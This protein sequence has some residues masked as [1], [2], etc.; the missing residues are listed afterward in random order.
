MQ[1]KPT[2]PSRT[3]AKFREPGPL[4]RFLQIED[5]CWL[6]HT[7]TF[8]R[9]SGAH[10]IGLAW[11][12]DYRWIF[13]LQTT[14]GDGYTTT[15]FDSHIG[16]RLGWTLQLPSTAN[17]GWRLGW[18]LVYNFL[19]QQTAV[20]VW[21]VRHSTTFSNSKQW[22]AF[23]L[24]GITTSFDSEQWSAFG[25]YL[26]HFTTSFDSDSGQCLG[27][28]SS[29]LPSTANSG[30]RLGWTSFYVITTSFRQQTEVGVWVG[31]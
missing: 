5:I 23:G 8:F 25:L 7:N 12:Q 31:R 1:T 13:P 6:T 30:R 27:W 28:T 29:Q 22:S 4:G 17:I 16:R 14:V 2:E 18:T 3:V 24:D 26:R 21:V 20:G 11:R 15:S 10:N 9:N 19:R